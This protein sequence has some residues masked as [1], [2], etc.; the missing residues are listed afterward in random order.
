MNKSLQ[1]YRDHPWMGVFPATLCAFQPDERI[2]EDGLRAYFAW[3]C[4]FPGLKGLVCNGHTGEIMALDPAERVRVTQ[5]LA[6]EVRRSGRP[7]K[8]LSGVAAEGSRV[9]IDHAKAARDAGADAIL[10]MPPHYQLRFG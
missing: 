1:T 2:D 3:L 7:L 6:E 10:L 9:A 8:V 4:T 5:I